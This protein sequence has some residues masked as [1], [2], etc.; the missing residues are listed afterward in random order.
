[1][2]IHM[3]VSFLLWFVHKKTFTDLINKVINEMINAAPVGLY[4]VTQTKT[5]ATAGTHS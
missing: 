3:I 1:M 2:N 4:T 5:P